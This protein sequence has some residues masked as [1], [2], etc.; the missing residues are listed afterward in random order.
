MA[1]ESTHA[2]NICIIAYQSS[3]QQTL[4]SQAVRIGGLYSLELGPE[5]AAAAQ[6]LRHPARNWASDSTLAPATASV[7]VVMRAPWG[8][9]GMRNPISNYHF[10][11]PAIEPK[12]GGGWATSP[13]TFGYGSSPG[14]LGNAT[15]SNEKMITAAEDLANDVVCSPNETRQ[16]N[17]RRVEGALHCAAS[18]TQMCRG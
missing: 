9:T 12:F 2:L 4:A 15:A 14:M 3:L 13:E 1:V 6:T 18:V 16:S 5:Y 7:D 17:P 10:Q 8:I 11:R